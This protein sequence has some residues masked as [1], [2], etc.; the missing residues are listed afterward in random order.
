[1]LF[2]LLHPLTLLICAACRCTPPH[3]APP[4]VVVLCCTVMECTDLCYAV[5]QLCRNCPVPC[6]LRRLLCGIC[7]CG[8][9]GNAVRNLRWRARPRSPSPFRLLR[10]PRLPPLRPRPG[11]SAGRQC[12]GP[13]EGDQGEWGSG[14]VDSAQRLWALGVCAGWGRGWGGGGNGTPGAGA[15]ILPGLCSAGSVLTIA[16]QILVNSLADVR[17]HYF[18]S[19][20]L[21]Q[22]CAHHCVSDPGQ[23][24]W[25]M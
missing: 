5:P 18:A 6:Y 2:G 3:I 22:Y 23:T 15:S 17:G 24:R 4:V 14:E 9:R 21:P 13:E 16:F 25:L 19:P 1:M 7:P 11:R 12:S 20:S 8:H 10:P